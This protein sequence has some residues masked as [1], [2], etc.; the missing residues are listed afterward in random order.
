M[1]ERLG[2]VVLGMSR[3]GTS[4]VAAMFVE[5]GFFA[6]RDEDVLPPHE[7]NP[8]GHHENLGVMRTNES[9]LAELAGSWYNPPSV[10][11]Q[12][13]ASERFTPVLRAQ[14][15]RM[16]EEATGQPIVV[17]DPRI[18]VMTR[19]WGPVLAD[20][21]HPVLVIRNPIE[22]SRS[23]LA[24]DGTPVPF[25]MAMW[26]LHMTALL[27]YLHGQIVTVAP[28]AQVL[29]DNTLAEEIVRI[30]AL[31]VDQ[32]RASRIRPDDAHAGID[33]DLHRNRMSD[34]DECQLLTT[35]Q[36][37]LWGF[38]DSL[39]LGDQQ[40][41]VPTHLRSPTTN[42]REVVQ[43]E[44]NRILERDRIALLEWRLTETQ[45]SLA[46][47]NASI[48][49]TTDYCEQLQAEVLRTAADRDHIAADRNLLAVDR[50]ELAER[51]L[52]V[53][54]SRRWRV[55]GPPARAVAIVRHVKARHMRARARG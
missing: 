11:D 14:V 26:E 34:G 25:G 47:A 33:P 51:Y 23:L 42:A 28:H 54:S 27:G 29:Q 3:S 53:V 55:M 21:L 17:K 12:V 31:H 48:A 2:V 18:G 52:G 4:A 35:R 9:V 20:Y 30:A 41:E 45:S 32:A 44:T 38:L 7:N 6:G 50:D 36:G 49:Q 5:A 1:T 15:E 22:I 39:A 37:E 43:C 13:A 40:L 16:A 8:R 46:D 19:L 10:A 24:R